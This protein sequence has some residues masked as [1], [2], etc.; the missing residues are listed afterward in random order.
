IASGLCECGCGEATTIAQRTDHKRGWVKG[1]PIRFRK[2]HNRRKGF[3][4]VECPTGYPT[5][6][7]IWPHAKNAAGYG[8]TTVSGTSTLAH[9]AS[10]QMYVDSIRL[11][12]DR[13]DR[14]MPSR[15]LA[16]TR[17]SSPSSRLWS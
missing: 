4:W 16:Y 17:R 12:R 15:W 1:K 3:T 5:P 10:Y 13:E 7:W 9:R 6:C 2:G 14:L 8:V 11:R